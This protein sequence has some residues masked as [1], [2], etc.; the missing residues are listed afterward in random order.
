M[1]SKR[2][3]FS[4]RKLKKSNKSKH[5]SKIKIVPN[6]TVTKLPGYNKTL[7]SKIYSGYI[8]LNEHKNIFFVLIESEN[9]PEKDPIMF[10]TNGG[11]GCSG[12][13]G[14]FEE[15][16]PFKP[17]K[18]GNLDYNPNTW[19][20]FAN[21]VFVEQPIGVGFSYSNLKK[22]YLSSDKK[23]S[24]DNLTFTIKFIEKFPKYKN[25]NMY[26]ISESYGGHYIPQWAD[27]IIKY[28]QNNKNKLNLKGFALGNPYVDYRAGNESQIETFWGH[29]RISKGIWEKYKESGCRKKNKPPD[30]RY[31]CNSL[32]YKISNKVG[33]I[34]PYAMSYPLCISNQEINLLELYKKKYK[35]Y[36]DYYNPC[37]NKY[38]IAYLN[39][40]DVQKIL[41]VKPGLPKWKYCSD[42]SK[43]SLKDGYKSQV[44][45]VNRFLNDKNLK[46]FDIMIMSG[47]NDSICST[48][49]TQEWIAELNIKTKKDWE[50]YFVNKEPAGYVSTYNAE[51]K[52][53]FIF[54]TVNDAGHEI[55]T[56]K[57]EVASHLMKNFLNKNILK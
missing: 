48:I 35:I 3:S 8:Q 41:H 38:T 28:N 29:Q 16:G 57:P 23:S 9:N 53:R 44:P 49:G 45:L 52:K 46:E 20:K 33:K 56:F 50:Q 37:I 1:V 26:L 13:I 4:K 7:P 40:K 24:E 30:L 14:L 32:S 5:K 22:D 51:G 12:L 54:S 31:K 17:N 55:A 42:R 19:T 25:N 18:N 6:Q 34:N 36:D 47:T 27:K 39:R 21:I 10:W 43:Y 2:K 15:M 11:P